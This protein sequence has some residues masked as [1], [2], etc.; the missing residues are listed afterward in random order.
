MKQIVNYIFEKLILNKSVKSGFTDEELMKDYNEVSY[1]Y[2]KSEKKQIADK[3]GITILKIRDIQLAILDLLRKNRNK[4]KEFTN[5]DI[6]NFFRYDIPDT[7]N[8]FI[9]YLDEEPIEFIEY[10]RQFYEEKINKEPRIKKYRYYPQ[11]LSIAD[12]HLL[13]ILDNLEKYLQS[14]S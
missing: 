10:L 14:K 12:R 6:S 4:K 5:K 11:M 2:T 3:Y 7:Y 9:K 8:K 13:K 1:A